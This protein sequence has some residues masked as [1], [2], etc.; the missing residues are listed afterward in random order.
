MKKICIFL[1]GMLLVSSSFFV[2][3]SKKKDDGKFDV[4]CTVFPAYDWVV[5]VVG[6]NKDNFDLDMLLDSGADLHSYQP[7][8][9]DI[10]KI[11][12][13]DMFIYVGGESDA[14]VS[15]VLAQKKNKDMIVINLMEV[16]ENDSGVVSVS[17]EHHDHTD[18]HLWLS[19]KHA[20]KFCNKIADEIGRLDT[21]NEQVYK[22]NASA[23]IEELETLDSDYVSAVDSAETKTMLFGD[24]FPFHY[25]FEDYGLTHFAAFSGCSAESESSFE[26]I[27]N[28]AAKIDELN[29]KYIIVLESSDKEV[30]K[31]IRN[32]TQNKNQE[33]LVIDSIQSVTSAKVNEGVKYLDIMK[34]NLNVLKTA[35]GVV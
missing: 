21:A 7:S 20:V 12:S 6:D 27:T 11:A 2:A 3:C 25:L 35:L 33:I 17:D 30:A 29:L 32:A 34:S 19:L 16:L 28:L 5:E 18:E 22:A 24:R 26:T 10:A 31:T 15:D 9:Q 1:L 14:W 23:Y 4:I 8:I 13:C